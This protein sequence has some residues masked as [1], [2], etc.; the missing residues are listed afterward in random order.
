MMKVVRIVCFTV[1]IAVCGGC[2]AQSAPMAESQEKIPSFRLSN[3][4]TIRAPKLSKRELKHRIWQQENPFTLKAY[5]RKVYPLAQECA[6]LLLHA[7]SHLA[8]I[9]SKKKRNQYIKQTEDSLFNLYK[10]PLKKLTR[11]QGRILIKLIDRQTGKSAYEIIRQFKSGSRTWMWQQT[12]WL[13]GQDL[14]TDYDADSEYLLEQ[15]IQEVE[16]ELGI[17]KKDK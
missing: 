16:A 10:E 17:G 1:Y 4:L 5:V 14:K 9:S 13:F 8:T 7:E 12:A 3:S 2:Y 6:K 15:A 11:Y